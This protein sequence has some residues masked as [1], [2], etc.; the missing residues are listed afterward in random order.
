ERI[1]DPAERARL[2]TFVVVGGG[3]TGVEM[4]G[5]VSELARQTLKRDFRSIHPGSARIVLVEGQPKVL[6]TFHEKLSA[7]AAEALRAMG[8]ELWFDFHVTDVTADHVTVTP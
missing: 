3:P 2:L 7:K 5:S 1:T 6:P 4:A 8:V